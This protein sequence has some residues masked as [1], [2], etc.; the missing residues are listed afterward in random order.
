VL[1]PIVLFVVGA[2]MQNPFSLLLLANVTD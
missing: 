1:V 2:T